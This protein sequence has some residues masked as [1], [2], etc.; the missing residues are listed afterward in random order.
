MMDFAA[1]QTLGTALV[2]VVDIVKGI[3]EAKP[4]TDADS[5]MAEL[6]TALLGAQGLALKA[7]NA[8]VELQKKVDGL[9]AQLKAVDD[10]GEQEFR[11]SLVC[12]WGNS[13]QVRA[14]NRESASE[15]ESP[16]FLCANCFLKRKRSML[17][18]AKGDQTKGDHRLSLICSSCNAA[19]YTDKRFLKSPLYSEEY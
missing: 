11:Y 10:W 7:M 5:K 4:G 3:R 2:S 19:V 17:N 15:G 9:E 18:P 12:P 16:H 1:I 6:M 14:L 8:Q 13:A